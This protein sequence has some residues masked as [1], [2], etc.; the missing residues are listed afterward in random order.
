[1]LILARRK[2]NESVP[3]AQIMNQVNAG[4]TAIPMVS[5]RITSPL[6]RRLSKTKIHPAPF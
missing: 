5:C 1:M 6:H 2:D 3:N 4:G